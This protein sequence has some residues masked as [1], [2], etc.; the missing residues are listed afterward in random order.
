[1]R[2][3]EQKITK[4]WG[5]WV[6]Q[7]VKCQLQL[8]S[9][10][11]G[12]GVQ[13]LCWQLRVW[14]LLQILCLPSLSLPLSHSYSVSLKNKINILQKFKKNRKLL[15]GNI[16][17]GG[18]LAMPISEDPCWRQARV[19][20]Y[21]R[22]KIK[23][24]IRYQGWGMFTKVAQWDFF[25]FNIC[26]FL[27]KRKRGRAE[28]RDRRCEVGSVLTAVSPIWGLNSL[29]ER[30]WPE[31]KSD[32]QPTEPARCPGSAGFLLS[33]DYMGRASALRTEPKDGTWPEGREPGQWRETAN[34]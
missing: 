13:A 11:H 18:I 20:R 26:L 1:M 24:L 30:S 8:R 22:W 5:A 12:L 2:V 29:T 25:F 15:R 31:L 10:S 33:L 21:E 3:S 9:W 14:S 19:G 7:W 34:V 28:S 23:N 4:R 27:R 6:A 32:A 16:K 17:G